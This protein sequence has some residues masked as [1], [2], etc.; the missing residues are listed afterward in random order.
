MTQRNVGFEIL[1]HCIRMAIF[2]AKKTPG[3]VTAVKQRD[4]TPESDIGK[5]LL[6]MLEQPPRFTDHFTTALTWRKCFVRTLRFP[7]KEKS[8][9]DAAAR[10]ELESRL[11]ADI[12]AY[13]VASLPAIKEEQGFST[14]SVAAPDADIAALL[15]PLDHMRLPV[16][17]LGLSPFAEADGVSHYHQNV[18]L[19]KAHATN[20]L[21]CSI[22]AGNIRT[23]KNC[24]AITA[25]PTPPAATDLA[26][27]IHQEAELLWRSAKLDPQPLLLIGDQVTAALNSALEQKGHELLQLPWSLDGSLVA[28]EFLPVCALAHAREDK[29]INLRRG[30]FALK[31]GW[32]SIKKHLYTGGILL[33]LSLV[34]AGTTAIVTYRHKLQQAETYRKQMSQI[35]H[36]TLPHVGVIVDIPRQLKAE[37]EQLEKRALLL[38]IGN[39]AS[40]LAALREI[41]RLTPEDIKLDVKRF[42]YDADKLDLTGVTTDFDSV[43]RLGAQLRQAPLFTEVRISDAKMGLEGNKVDFR[44]QLTLST[45]GGQ[46]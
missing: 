21:I 44:L 4:I 27:R 3:Q 10:I 11:P 18:L 12:S 1:P 43:N 6:E 30:R 16:Q 46:P 25:S 41:S 2:D 39:S 20:L 45:T 5:I 35:F 7:F 14:I 22:N 38:G 37:L 23:Y 32:S 28:P 42:K 15:T 29:S 40:A 33:T 26:Q 19:V 8:K 13:T 36:Q 9:I 31:G 17:M 24:G 34:L